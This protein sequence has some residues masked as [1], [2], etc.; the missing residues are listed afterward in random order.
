LALASVAVAL[1]AC[2]GSTSPAAPGT[3]PFAPL[4]A[5][6]GAAGNQV[7]LSLDADG[8]LVASWLEPVGEGDELGLKFA[9]F[10]GTAWSAPIVVAHG[11]DWVVS[12][13]DLPSVR[14]LSERLF[15]ADWRVPSEASPYAYDIAVALSA[16]GGATWS[17]PRRLNDDGTPTEHGF[18][19][20]FAAGDGATAIWLDGRDLARDP[21]TAP[22]GTPFGTSL[23]Y[24]VFDG[25]GGRRDEGVVDDLVCDCCR[26]DV[27]ATDAGIAVIYRDRSAQ[28]IR[29]IRVRRL[30]GRA[31]SEGVTLGPDNWEIEGCPINGPAVAARGRE[32]VAAWFT[33]AGDRGRVR[34]AR[35]ADGARSF[36]APAE[37]DAEGAIGQVGIALAS[38]GVAYVSWWR[39]GE[40]GAEL[41][42]RA[43]D[44]D[45]TLGPVQVVAST[46]VSRPESVPQLALAHGRL[47]LAWADESELTGQAHM[48]V[49]TLDGGG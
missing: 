9:R 32:V 40:Q 41:A 3:L 30:D 8:G 49:A 27:A 24:A 6:L 5:P 2:S 10:N 45:G 46:T 18:V 42:L 13:A 11:E 33:A 17:A 4:E 44:R 39:R 19:S 34:F 31:W 25:A 22:D 28:E 35:S 20:W 12:S 43:V 26:T 29:D 37:I 16:D 14:L 1:T 7:R 15:A 21:P 47:A 36:G 23:R 38:S 48:A